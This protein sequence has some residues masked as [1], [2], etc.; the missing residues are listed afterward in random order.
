MPLYVTDD[1]HPLGG[2]VP[3]TTHSML[4]TFRGCHREAMYKYHMRLQPKRLSKPLTRGKWLHDLLEVHYKGGDWRQQ[5]KRWVNKFRN[6]FDEEKEDLGSELPTEI[7]QLMESYFWH[8]EADEWEVLDTEL[9]VEAMLPNGHLFRGKVDILIQNQYGEVWAGDHK[10][11]KRLPDWDFRMLDEQSTLYSWALGEMGK[12][13]SGFFWNYIST[14][15]MTMPKVTQDGKRFYKSQTNFDYL[16][17]RQALAE[18]RQTYG[19]GWPTDKEERARLRALAASLK[20]QRYDPANPI[21]TSPHFRRD[22]LV[23]TNALIERVLAGVV[24]TSDDM[25]SYDFSDEMSVERNVNTCKS[26]LCH[27][28]SLNIADL[29]NGDSSMTQKREYTHEDPLAYYNGESE[30]ED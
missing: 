14:A 6:L 19:P 30:E 22:Y 7:A 21:Q 18:A 16:V 24:R 23:K 11:H 25:H 13:V 8:Y 12:P 28:K 4:K 1:D 15:G 2:G 27:Y 17:F 10:S 20:A 5:H 26:F 3:V 9:L 29:V